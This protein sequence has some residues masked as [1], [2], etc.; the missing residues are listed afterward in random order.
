M[1]DFYVYGFKSRQ[2]F[3]QKSLRS[4]DNERRRIESY[5]KD[6]M[7]F[8][9]SEEGKNVFLS[10]D[11]RHTTQNPLYQ[12][13]LA[14]SFTDIGWWWARPSRSPHPDAPG[15]G[16]RSKWRCRSDQKAALRPCPAPR[17]SACG[18]DRG[19]CTPHRTAARCRPPS[20]GQGPARC[21]E[22]SVCIPCFSL[23]TVPRWRG[24]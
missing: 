9:Q 6:Y 3:D 2:D 10:I 16:R 11:S 1:I 21:R 14:K 8:T 15:W 22:W 12:A 7:R 23:L 17:S 18:P 19:R 13:F 4:Y 20:A 5:L 24:G